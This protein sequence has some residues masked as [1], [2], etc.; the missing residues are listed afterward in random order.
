MAVTVKK[1]IL[2]CREVDN[3]PG[4]LASVLQPLSEAGADLQVV[5][6]YRYPG[7]ENKAA[8]ELYPVSGRK[9]GAAAQ[10]A[11]LQDLI[12]RNARQD[13]AEVVE[14]A[15]DVCDHR[16]CLVAPASARVPALLDNEQAPFTWHALEVVC[17]AIDELEV[18]AGDQ[19]L[20]GAGDQYLIRRGGRCDA[21][22]DMHRDTAD[23]VAD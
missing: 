16:A 2:W 3:S 5:M 11:G 4:I 10:T 14:L 17:T 9:S 20:D 18:G 21:G 6:A 8:I 12:R 13:S 7:G 15:I 23:I 19:V 22:T 1:A